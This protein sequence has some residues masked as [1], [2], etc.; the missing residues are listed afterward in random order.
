MI[1]VVHLRKLNHPN[2]RQHLLLT[3]ESEICGYR[4]SGNVVVNRNDGG[5]VEGSVSVS[6]ISRDSDAKF[7]SLF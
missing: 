7:Q 5:C 4:E 3:L 1:Y 2:L 6:E